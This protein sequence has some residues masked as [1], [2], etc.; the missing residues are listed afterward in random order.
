MSKL[1][2]QEQRRA[3]IEAMNTML[4]NYTKDGKDVEV[5][6]VLDN[7]MYIHGSSKTRTKE[8]FDLVVKVTSRD[9][10]KH[11]WYGV[12]EGLVSRYSKEESKPQQTAQTAQPT[13]QPSQQRQTEPKAESKTETKAE[14]ATEGKTEQTTG[15]A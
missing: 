8:Y 12:F 3:M 14:P 10:S 13:Q 4:F 7:F 15:T 5:E 2:P 6:T 9:N 11:Y 1:T